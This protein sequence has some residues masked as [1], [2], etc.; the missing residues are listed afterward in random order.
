MH[1]EAELDVIVAAAQAIGRTLTALEPLRGSRR[2]RVFRAAVDG[3]PGT[4][5]VKTH[6]PGFAD[7]W[8]RES[9]A[10]TVLRGRGLPVPDLIAVVDEPPLVV[11]EVLGAGPSLADA[12]LG[13]SAATATT[14][15]N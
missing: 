6:E 13:R 15:L 14:R 4:V 2:T 7:H 12:L 11:L 9:A 3:G 10:L 8:A 5:I 1:K